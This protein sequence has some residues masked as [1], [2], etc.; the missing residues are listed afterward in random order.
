MSLEGH[1]RQLAI[2]KYTNDGFS[3]VSSTPVDGVGFIQP[4]GGN[5]SFAH[6][7]LS[8]RVNGRLYCPIDQ[9][10]KEG[11]IIQQGG[12]YWIVVFADLPTG[13]GGVS[14]HKEC[15]LGKYGQ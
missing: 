14:H 12:V 7:T 2:T 5:E 13:A 1:Y 15:L 11:D 10:I 6:L 9:A 4:I 8:Q 3:I